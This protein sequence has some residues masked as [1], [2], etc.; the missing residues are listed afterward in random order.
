MIKTTLFCGAILTSIPF[1]AFAK[2]YPLEIKTLSAEQ[3][4]GY[5]WSYGA[6]Q[7]IVAAKPAALKQTPKAVS[8][9]PLYGEFKWRADKASMLFRLDESKGD[10]KGYDRL[11]LDLNQNGDL[12]DD[13]AIA[14]AA[15]MGSWSNFS[16][17]ELKLFG[18]LEAPASKQIAAGKLSYYAVL[19]IRTNAV[20]KLRKNSAAARD[21][22]GNLR[23]RAGGYLETTVE[24]DGR[25][26]SVAV[27]D[28]DANM[29]LGDLCQANI[30]SDGRWFLGAADGDRLLLKKDDSGTNHDSRCFSRILYFDATP[31]KVALAADCGSLQIEP[32]PEPLV[33]VS[34]QPQGEQV[35]DLGLGWESAKGQ[36]QFIEPGVAHGKIQLPRGNYGLWSVSLSA[37]S[38]KAEELTVGGANM[39]SKKIFTVEPGTT[40][41]L[42]CGAPL[43]VIVT[44]D[45]SGRPAGSSPG[46]FWSSLLNGLGK[47]VSPETDE[48]RIQA[49]IVGSG[50]EQY[51]SFRL[52]QADGKRSE[53]PRPTFAIATA[54]GKPVASGNLEFG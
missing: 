31:Y 41:T 20:L 48:L 22:L 46:G 40:N 24:I 18:P 34:L 1:L 39:N 51:S 38:P 50:G 35:H 21:Y 2:D 29:R 12:T 36:W 43:E 32:W 23:L 7:M 13:A 8:A 19:D 4:K 17:Q 14:P 47:V 28:N 49:E 5:Q 37:K 15:G 44:T 30:T 33:E 10:G 42:R 26:Q 25:K 27:I 9:H 6:V 45:R 52:K 54:D 53:P 16:G 3:V 11:I